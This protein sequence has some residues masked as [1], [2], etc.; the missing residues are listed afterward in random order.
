MLSGHTARFHRC[1]FGC[2][3]YGERPTCPPYSPAP[4]MVPAL[5]LLLLE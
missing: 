1:Q 5:M 2:K 4:E 3:H